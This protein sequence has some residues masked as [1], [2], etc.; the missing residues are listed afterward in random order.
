M[1][2][3]GADVEELG[4][5]PLHEPGD[6]GG[7]LA[8]LFYKGFANPGAARVDQN[9][10]TRLRIGELYQTCLG[11]FVLE[12]VGNAHRDAIVAAGNSAQGALVAGVDE[13]AE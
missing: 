10:R 11:K 2:A 8:C 4:P 6:G 3:I 13:V 9:A 5:C 12:R 1:T 7:T